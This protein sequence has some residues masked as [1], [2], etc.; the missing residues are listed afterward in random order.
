[1]CNTIYTKQFII[2][3][4]SWVVFFQI[5]LQEHNKGIYYEYN[6]PKNTSGSTA[7]SSYIWK[8]FW[9]PCSGTCGKGKNY[10]ML[11]KLN[12]LKFNEI[13]RYHEN[14][15]R[16]DLNGNVHWNLSILLARKKDFSSSLCQ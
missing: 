12:F 5:I 3:I 15:I 6:F 13:S 11:L 8:H 16:V 14:A 9:S 4:L 7:N 2:L 1:M 10:S